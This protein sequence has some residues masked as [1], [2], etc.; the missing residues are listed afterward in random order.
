MTLLISLTVKRCGNCPKRNMIPCGLKGEIIVT[1]NSSLSTL[2]ISRDLSPQWRNHPLKGTAQEVAL[3]YLIIQGG[4]LMVLKP[5][6]KALT[7]EKNREKALTKEKS[8]GKTLIG[9][10]DC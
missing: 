6:G 7:G 4:A 1:W 5:Q 9:R 3:T 2:S 8:H 10:R